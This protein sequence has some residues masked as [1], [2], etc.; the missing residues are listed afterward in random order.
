[1]A[2]TFDGPNKIVQLD[3]TTLIYTAEFIYSRWKDWLL[4]GD[5]AKFLEAFRIVGGDDLGGGAKAPA[6]VF[7]R[8]DYG[9]L[10]RKPEAD[11]SVTI[12]GNLVRED[13]LAGFDIPPVGDFSPTLT[14]NLSSVA[15]SPTI[16]NVTTATAPTTDTSLESVAATVSDS[17][18]Q[19][20]APTNAL[21]AFIPKGLAGTVERVS[22]AAALPEPITAEACIPC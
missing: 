1:M 7:L 8:N 9:W 10:I 2:I 5:N 14:L 15:S 21:S 16:V 17:S 12:N 20:H 3:T 19:F 18:I 11:I 6:Y 13:P 22:V 4:Q